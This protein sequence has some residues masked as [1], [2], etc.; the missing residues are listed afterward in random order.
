[1]VIASKVISI[2]KPALSLL[3]LSLLFL[4]LLVCNWSKAAVASTHVNGTLSLIAGNIDGPGANDGIGSEA[5]FSSNNSFNG[6]KLVGMATDAIGNIFIADSGNH[7]IRKITP[8]GIVT[9][10]AGIAG[11]PGS[12][13]GLGTAAQFNGPSGIAIDKNGNLY[14]ADMLNHTIRKISRSGDVSTMAG[15]AGKEGSTDGMGAAARFCKPEGIAADSNGNLFVVD[16]GNKT[17]RKINPD[18]AVTTFAGTVG[19]WGYTNGVGIIAQFAVPFG[20]TI[21]S[22]NIIY[23]SDWGKIRKI[24]PTGLVSNYA[25]FELELPPD[26]SGKKHRSSKQPI[27]ITVD[28][29]GNLYVTTKQNHTICK[30]NSSGVVTTVAGTDGITGSEDGIGFAAKFKGLSGIIA[31]ATGNLF[32]ADMGNAAIRKITPDGVVTT[33]AGRVRRGGYADGTG[34]AAR[35]NNPHGVAV[36]PSGN[37]YVADRENNVIRK[38]TTSGV[39]TTVAGTPG[40]PGSADGRVATALFNMPTGLA[41]DTAGNLYVADSCTIR[42]ISLNKM[43]T[44]LSGKAGKVGSVDGEGELA[45]F[46]DPRG[47]AVHGNGDIYVADADAIRKI[48]QSGMVSTVAGRN[49]RVGIWP[50]NGPGWTKSFSSLSGIVVDRGGVVYVSDEKGYIYKRMPDGMGS[51]LAGSVRE[52]NID[53]FGAAARFKGPVGLTIDG[54]GYLYVADYGNHTI[55]RITPSGDVTTVAGGTGRQGIITVALPWG[56]DSPNGLARMGPNTFVVISGNA[57]LKLTVKENGTRV[58]SGKFAKL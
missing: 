27:G 38:I 3:A 42:K 2:S 17:I 33:F 9:T 36:D 13:D 34:A 51:T 5:R 10:L 39:V 47:I 57:L 49:R 14:V 55:R 26:A 25:N 11:K 21:D 40:K 48:T 30:I 35:F 31:D 58:A 20:I 19:K 53:G 44:T 12:V 6:V 28:T 37:I 45:R 7:T 54:L 43:V 18:G 22:A 24:L 32:V 1:M 46:L 50:D 29:I 16:F 23:V 8:T 4:G 52:G 56:L 41:F 15:R